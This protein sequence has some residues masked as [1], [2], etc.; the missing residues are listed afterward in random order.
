MDK[1]ANLA[2]L[3]PSLL[4]VG[5]AGFA[6]LRATDLLPDPKDLA[7]NEH[8]LDELAQGI[9]SGKMNPKPERFLEMLH[10]AYRRRYEAVEGLAKAHAIRSRFLGYSMLII[11]L[12][13]A[14]V[15]FR[16]RASANAATPNGGVGTR[17]GNSLA[18]RT[19]MQT[20]TA[21]LLAIGWLATGA[22]AGGAAYKLLVS[23][24]AERQLKLTSECS[25]FMTA[26]PA[27]WEL[28]REHVTEA[29]HSLEGS[30][31]AGVANMNEFL[32]LRAD[33]GPG[34]SRLLTNAISYRLKFPPP[35]PST[36][37]PVWQRLGVPAAPP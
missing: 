6:L 18:A 22:L 27:L 8:R 19:P 12:F 16:V 25:R 9:S 5:L 33:D 24:R 35:P 34:T 13:Q 21:V 30:L 3:L 10:S 1:K 29:I 15:V 28:R 17:L 20:R 14:W 7:W 2:L 4:L 31:D 23:D 32:P 36:N 11:V 26:L 37:A